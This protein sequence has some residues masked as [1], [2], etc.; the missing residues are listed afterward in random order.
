M[1]LIDL[2]WNVRQQ[3]DLAE[4]QSSLSRT[5]TRAEHAMRRIAE[6]EE[7]VDSLAVALDVALEL[8]ARHTGLS[9]E[10]FRAKLTAALAERVSSQ[11]AVCRGCQRKSIAS[12]MECL[13]CGETFVVAPSDP[14]L[15]PG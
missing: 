4:Q 12:R 13:Y 5:S 14:P 15:T 8:L 1:G 3:Q 11:W 7:R 9:D 6:L 10:E 2:I